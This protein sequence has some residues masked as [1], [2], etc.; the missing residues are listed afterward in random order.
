[1]YIYNNVTQVY[2]LLSELLYYRRTVGLLANDGVLGTEEALKVTIYP[3]SIMCK[4][5]V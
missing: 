2:G 3:Y 4:H 1:M 5:I